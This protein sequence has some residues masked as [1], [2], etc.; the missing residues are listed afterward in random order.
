LLP[1]TATGRPA[2]SS[3]ATAVTPAVWQV[4][5]SPTGA[6]VPRSNTHTVESE[7]RRRHLW[8]C[9]DLKQAVVGAEQQG[10]VGSPTG[11][12]AALVDADEARDALAGI[13]GDAF[14]ID[15]MTD[16]E[17]AA[18]NTPTVTIRQTY[19]TVTVP[20]P[21]ANPPDGTLIGIRS[22]DVEPLQAEASPVVVTNADY[23][24]GAI[25]AI[26]M[27]YG[28][29]FQVEGTAIMI[30]L[31]LAITAK[32]VIDDHHAR[33][34][35]GEGVLRCAGL[36]PNGVLEAWYC[37]SITMN[38]GPGDLALLSLRV[39]SPVPADGYFRTLS[40][41]TRVPAPGEHLNVV[42]VRFREGPGSVDPV[43]GVTDA[44]EG[45]GLM[46]VS[47]GAA[48]AFSF[49]AHDSVLAPYPT[50]EILSGT[51][52]GMSGGA[53]L[54]TSGAVVGIISRGWR[55]DDREGP[56]LAAW[57]T[58]LLLWRPAA[59]GLPGVDEP[60]TPVFE[61]RTVNILGRENVDVGPGG[62]FTVS[63]CEF[64]GE[65]EPAGMDS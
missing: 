6:P 3:T 39:A 25:L 40:L 8:A 9:G 21:L 14:N 52:G 29:Q 26:G 60:G 41:S 37:Y 51:F 34:Q 56:T 20:D 48:G 32:H 19:Q 49:P 1:L 15:V 12:A 59:S 30:G 45:T 7:R 28:D 43:T 17:G 11:H 18:D 10:I 38:S 36:R 16:S 50:I 57:W 58:P 35:A 22:V 27:Q 61:M 53:V 64:P 46:F 5:G 2:S 13:V 44:V 23:F 42:G 65:G 47:S 4:N 33:W 54:D 55:T 24:D 31:G 63:G 62:Q